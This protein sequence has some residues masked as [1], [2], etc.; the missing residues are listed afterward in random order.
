M[1]YAAAVAPEAL[2]EL[3]KLD[4][5]PQEAVLDLLDRLADEGPLLTEGPQFHDVLVIDGPT[6]VRMLLWIDVDHA[7]RVVRLAQLSRFGM[8]W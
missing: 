6:R 3:Q 5:E 7:H 4:I 8:R 2:I 1:S